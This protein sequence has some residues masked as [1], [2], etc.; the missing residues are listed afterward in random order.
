M[1]TRAL[2][3][4]RKNSN[5]TENSI[6]AGTQQLMYFDTQSIPGGG[7]RFVDSVRSNN[8]L[9]FYGTPGEYSAN[10]KASKYITALTPPN[11][12]K[13]MFV[14]YPNSNTISKKDPFPGIQEN[15]N[16]RSDGSPF[17]MVMLYFAG[18]SSLTLDTNPNSTN[19]K[20]WI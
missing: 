9:K 13:V 3:F 2:E 5:Y 4:Y 17:H 10:F 12:G 20:N 19:Y 7:S 6:K 16:G 8:G 14:N 15:D 1:N 11:K 18:K